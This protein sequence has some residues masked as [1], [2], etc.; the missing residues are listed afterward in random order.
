MD[1]TKT[2]ISAAAGLVL[3][4]SA[5]VPVAFAQDE[6]PVTGSFQ[7][8]SVAPTVDSVALDDTDDV[9]A[10]AMDPQVEFYVAVDVTDNNT[11]DD[12]STVGVTIFYDADGTYAPA[13]VPGTGSAQ[14]AAILTWTNGSGWSIDAGAGTS[15]S[16]EAGNCVTP[17]LTNSTGTFEFHFRPGKVATET[18]ATSRWHIYAEADDGAA[19]ADNYQ[20]NRTMNWYGEITAITGSVDW[21]S[22]TPGTGFTDDVNEVGAISMTY[23]AN[24]PY[25]EQVRSSSTWTGTSADATFDDTGTCGN[26]NEFSLQAND[27]DDF[28]NAV[29]VDTTGATIDDTGTQTAEGGDS[30][31]ANTL[32]LRL[33]S[34]F[35]NDTYNGTITYIIA[36]G[37]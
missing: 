11:L 27:L 7:A 32:W 23:V 19:T 22:V 29:Q 24:G 21:G 30:V 2:L 4:L 34:V 8:A 35:A 17:T 14:T 13:D 6:G 16:I 31:A 36:E 10:T 28:N 33:A 12:L 26:D 25:D 15:W 3:L 20:D 9:A 5:A 1:K 37:S 18:D